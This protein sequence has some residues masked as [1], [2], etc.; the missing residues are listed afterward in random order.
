MKYVDFASLVQLGVGLHAGTALLQTYGEIGV[1]PFMRTLE[2]IRALVDE[3]EKEDDVVRDKFEELSANF[4]IFRI[5]LFNEFKK[6]VLINSLVA[7]VLVICLV[8]IS[9]KAEAS[10]SEGAAAFFVILSIAP[11]PITLGALWFDASQR[12]KP[13]K[14]RA[15]TL[16]SELLKL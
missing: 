10:L 7:A 14:R 16:E 6:Y 1:Q 12:L 13:L 8:I 4:D 2:R 15:E 11:A 9:Y 3:S 5:Q